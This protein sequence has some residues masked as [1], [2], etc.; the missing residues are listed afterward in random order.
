MTIAQQLNIT[1]FPFYIKDEKGELIYREESNGFWWKKEY[2]Q[3]G[4]QIYFEN[5]DGWWVKREFDQDGNQIYFENSG[6]YWC[7]WE[8]DQDGNQIYF[9]NSGGYIE[10]NRPKPK[11]EP[12]KKQ[13]A[14]EWL[15]K[16][17]TNRQNGIFDGFPHLSLDEIYS[18]AKAIEKENIEEAWCDGNDSEPKEITGDFAEQYFNQTYG[19]D[20]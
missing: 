2:D 20:K 5:S 8:F 6:G 18:Q 1:T 4:H 10:D 13:T 7:K 17:L 15:I 3:N 11:P 19:G 16:K 14:V 9:E 12:V